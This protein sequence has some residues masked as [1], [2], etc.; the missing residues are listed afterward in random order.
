MKSI[1]DRLIFATLVVGWG[2]S[3]GNVNVTL[4]ANLFSPSEDGKKIEPDPAIVA[5][6]RLDIS[7]ARQLVQNLT[8]AIAAHD[9]AAAVSKTM[10]QPEE[11]GKSLN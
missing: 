4:G 11:E 2:L 5:R 10:Q 1:D 8:D 7:C 3:N 9:T 6:L